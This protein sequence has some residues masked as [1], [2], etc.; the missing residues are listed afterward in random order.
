M[1][2]D[3]A[4]CAEVPQFDRLSYFYG[5]MLHARDLQIEQA[6]FRDKLKLHN[7][8]LHGWG[9]V[10]GLEIAPVPADPDCPPR[11]DVE[12]ARLQAALETC[13]KAQGEATEDAEKQRLAA[14]GE[15]LRRQIETL[16]PPSNCTHPDPRTRILI[17]CGLAI[18]CA[19]NELV[20]RQPLPIDLWDRLSP[21]CHA[22]LDAGRA[23]S[24]YVAI[25]YRECPID[26]VRPVMPDPCG[27]T[28]E[29]NYGKVRDGISVVVSTDAERWKDDR[30]D[31]C[32]ESCTECCVLLARIDGYVKEQP[33][34]P[35]QIHPEVRRPLSLRPATTIVG[36]NWVQGGE[37]TPHQADHLLGSATEEEG[38]LEIRFSRP[39]L[40]ETIVAGTVDVWVI[41]GGRGRA[42]GISYK[43]GVLVLPETPTTDRIVYRDNTSESLNEGDRVLVIVHS[44]FLLDECCRPVDGAHVG[45][46]VPRL[47]HSPHAKV[48]PEP[49]SCTK[50]PHGAGPWTSGA[51]GAAANFESWFW[52]DRS[53]EKKR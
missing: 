38:G 48:I 43:A 8:C 50:L 23:T 1:K 33:L 11:T 51:G 27:A 16:G 32:C 35:E 39:I 24:L 21:E 20:L 52:I 9:V 46:R 28:S 14:E 53:E 26:P 6:Y 42:A 2:H 30:C 5:Q 31:V 17:E 49:T 15:R 41:E 7:R 47:P 25:C 18:D 36:I 4:S 12:R 13:R 22:D 10:C 40:T 44:A 45:G 34:T 19:G 29:C 37:Y 3:R